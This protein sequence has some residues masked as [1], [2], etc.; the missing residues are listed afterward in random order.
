[1]TD[2]LDGVRLT[3]MALAE[4]YVP[5]HEMLDG[6]VAHFVRQGFTLEQARAIT[7]AEFV[8][9]FGASIGMTATRPEDE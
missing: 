3:V 6:E 2:R 4:N 8:G 9:T 1:M 7:A 5:L